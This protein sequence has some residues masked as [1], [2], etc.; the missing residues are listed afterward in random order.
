MLNNKLCFG[1]EVVSCDYCHYHSEL[2]FNAARII[3]VLF[4]QK[5]RERERDNP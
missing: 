4:G 5:E 3:E 1:G 2:I